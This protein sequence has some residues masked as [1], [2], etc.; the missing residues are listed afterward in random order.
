MN[1]NLK[2]Y[3]FLI[4]FLAILLFIYLIPTLPDLSQIWLPLS[5][6]V[7]ISILA[8]FI[9]VPLPAGGEITIAFPIDF[10]VILVYGP[11]LA[12]MVAILGIIWKITK[13]KES[14]YKTIFNA[15]QYS[16]ATGL[17][18]IVYIYSGGIVGGENL[19]HYIIPAALSALIYCIIN[20]QKM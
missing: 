11:A 2:L 6:F 7:I 15:A 18:G 20:L 5:F 10:L 1:R 19:Y 13:K 4:A 12:M 17:A 3:I 9:P 14:W 8:E 16:I